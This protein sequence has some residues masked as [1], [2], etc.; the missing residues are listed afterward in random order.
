MLEQFWNAT[1]AFFA[2][3]RADA[4]RKDIRITPLEP[5]DSKGPV[6]MVEQT[7]SPTLFFWASMT[8]RQIAAYAAP[9]ANDTKEAM[10]VAFGCPVFFNGE[11]WVASPGIADPSR[12]MVDAMIDA[13][14]WADDHVPPHRR[15]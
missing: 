12:A 7:G 2:T 14:N 6:F 9:A 1:T 15:A 11:A 10:D 4:T 3:I 8:R 5:F 13:F